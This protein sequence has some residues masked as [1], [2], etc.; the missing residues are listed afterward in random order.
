VKPVSTRY[1]IGAVGVAVGSRMVPPGPNWTAR[2][3]FLRAVER[4][5]PEALTTLSPMAEAGC[6]FEWCQRWNL[7]DPWLHEVAA[8]TAERLAD[9]STGGF[10]FGPGA[11]FPAA[12]LASPPAWDPLYE[13]SEAY[14]LKVASYV[15]ESRATLIARGWR[16]APTKEEPKHFEW[17]AKFQLRGL[18][19]DA[20]VDELEDPP[21]R[22]TVSRGIKQTAK[23]A[24]VTLR[25][26]KLQ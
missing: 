4:V 20:V 6:L 18:T 10:Q 23:I 14:A 2:A 1:S 16:D 5:V 21:D 11:S 13:S 15:K 26:A 3:L 24:D 17:L 19:L 9:G 7:I 22:A 8:S 25:T 12:Q